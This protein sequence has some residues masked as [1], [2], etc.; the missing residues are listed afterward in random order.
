VG[1]QRVPGF[2]WSDRRVIVL[3]PNREGDLLPFETRRPGAAA[4]LRIGLFSA[5]ARVIHRAQRAGRL[6]IAVI[7]RCYIFRTKT[8]SG[9]MAAVENLN[10]IFHPFSIAK[11]PHPKHLRTD[12]D[13][14]QIDSR[15]LV[16]FSCV[17]D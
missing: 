10:F 16:S 5:T 9:L 6:E 8:T 11:R 7:K 17:T 1:L 3:H 2:L 14:P 13:D 4:S 12:V 15:L